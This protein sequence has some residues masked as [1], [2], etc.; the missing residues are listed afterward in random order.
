MRGDVAVEWDASVVWRSEG[1]R[2]GDRIWVREQHRCEE[3][4]WMG[5]VLI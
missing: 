4:R 1:G 5:R 2:D 3:H